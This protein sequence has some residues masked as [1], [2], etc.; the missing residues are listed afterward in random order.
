MHDFLAGQGLNEAAIKLVFDTAPYYGTTS[1]DAASLTYAFNDGWIKAQATAGKG[2][3]AVRGGNQKLPMAMRG[4]LKGDVLLNKAVAAIHS[5]ATGV[6]VICRDGSR[7]RARRV[8]SSLP[9]AALR[10]ITIEPRLTG[11]QAQAVASLPYQPLSIAFL[12]VTAPFW[13]SDPVSM[14][15]DGPL[16]AVLAQRYGTTDDEVTGLAVFARGQLAQ[17]WDAMGKAS[18]LAMIVAELERLRPAAQG[19]VIGAALHSWALEPFN[20]GDWAYFHSGQIS[21]FAATMALPAGR[22]H[23]CGEHTATANRGI[24]AALESSERVALEILS[25]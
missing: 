2:S 19:K 7:H 21:A 3:F 14:W 5:D 25:A 12:R 20:G 9:F 16:G 1:R 8:V 24:E 23:F 22:L 18:A 15:T 10:H 4:L 11:P 13:G 6:T 17:R